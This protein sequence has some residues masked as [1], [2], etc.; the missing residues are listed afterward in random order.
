[1]ILDDNGGKTGKI[2][3]NAEWEAKSADTAKNHMFDEPYA[4]WHVVDALATSPDDVLIGITADGSW[5]FLTK[6]P[7]V[8]PSCKGK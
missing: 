1:M 4:H 8:D 7:Q 2:P 5:P 3:Y 6:V